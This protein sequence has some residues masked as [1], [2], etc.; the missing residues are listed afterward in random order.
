[1]FPRKKSIVTVGGFTKSFVDIS[2]VAN[3]GTQQVS[4]DDVKN[5]LRGYGM[6]TRTID[7]T[8]MYFVRDFNNLGY[9]LNSYVIEPNYYYNLG[10]LP[11]QNQ[12]PNES[13]NDDSGPISVDHVGRWDIDG[14][15]L[16]PTTDL[17]PTLHFY[18]TPP[19]GGYYMAS[20]TT[21]Y[22]YYIKFSVGIPV[23]SV[24]FH[25]KNNYNIWFDQRMPNGNLVTGG[26]YLL[27]IVGNDI[28]IYVMIEPNGQEGTTK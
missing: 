25:T 8:P 17:T 6:P 2:E 28:M 19:G 24:M 26:T 23:P 13:S 3:I 18:L 22:E 27:H 12:T 16:R 7:E 11:E 5:A 14:D 10:I 9:M 15:D 4:E 21:V 20:D 1:M